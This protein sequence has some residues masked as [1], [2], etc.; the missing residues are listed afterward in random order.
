MAS[1]WPHTGVVSTDDNH[2]ASDRAQTVT[3]NVNLALNTW[4]HIAFTYE[5]GVGIKLYLNGVMVAQRTGVT[6]VLEVSSG[7]PVTIGRLVQPFAGID[8]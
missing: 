8:R 3:A 1:V 2:A 5:S 7:A 6:G 4:Y